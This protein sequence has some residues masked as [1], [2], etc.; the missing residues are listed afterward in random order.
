MAGQQLVVALCCRLSDPTEGSASEACPPWGVV[1]SLR[2]D[3]VPDP[4]RGGPGSNMAISEEGAGVGAR[5][6]GSGGSVI[7]RG[8]L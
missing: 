5:D 8:F 2:S 4:L 7:H 1:P 6:E 3:V